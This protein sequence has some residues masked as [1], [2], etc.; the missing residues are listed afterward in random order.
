[1]ASRKAKKKAPVRKPRKPR[2]AR[3]AAPAKRAAGDFY[4]AIKPYNSG[5]LRVSTNE[6]A[7]AAALQPA[8]ST[9]PPGTWCPTSKRSA[10]I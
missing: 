6:A 1:M 2:M 10:S 9:T 3:K 4:P 7:D 5:F 8:W